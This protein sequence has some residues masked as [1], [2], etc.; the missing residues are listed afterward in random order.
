MTTRH[1]SSRHAPACPS[2][3]GSSRR[4]TTATRALLLSLAVGLVVTGCLPSSCER[5]GYDAVAPADSASRRVAQA[6]PVD[7]LREGWRALGPG[8]APLQFPRTVRYLSSGGALVAS[9]AE[10]DALYRFTPDGSLA[11]SFADDRLDVPYLIGVRPGPDTARV[12]ADTLVVLSPGTDR[13]AFVVGERVLDAP[14][15][16]FERPSDDALVYGAAT[17]TSVYLKF[18]SDEAEGRYIARLD[19]RGR[20][21]ATAR[22]PGPQWRH[23]GGLT[24]WDDT[25]ASLAGF[26]PV[27]DVLPL[28]FADGAA[29]D[30]MRLVGFDSP[31]LPRTYAYRQGDVQK[32]PLLTTSATA[33]AGHLFVLNLRPGWVQVDA[34]GHDGRLRRILSTPDSA[35]SKNFYPRDLS[36]RRAAD[37]TYHLGIAFTSPQARVATYTWTPSVPLRRAPADSAM[38]RANGAG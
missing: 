24:V 4:W 2:R 20:V 26:Q 27:V 14:G 6:T 1:A 11:A 8:E 28:D 7:T 34:Y 5:S 18:V 33:A 29:P 12:A 32:P 38:A 13:V 23:A 3:A 10:R 37:G 16:T 19:R 22:L 31:M 9:D 17:D 15:F 25:L 21:R 30:S 36:V 35:L